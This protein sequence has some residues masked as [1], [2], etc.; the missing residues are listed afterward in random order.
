MKKSVSVKFPS[1][2]TRMTFISRPN[3][4]ILHCYSQTTHSVEVVHLADPGRLKELLIE[5]VGIYVLPSTNPN[6]KTKWTA[7]LVE[8]KEG[9]VSINTTF[10]NMLVDKMVK[11]SI[12]PELIDYK[13]IKSEYTYGHSRWDFLLEH[14]NGT[15]LLLEVK[16]VTL[17][18][19]GIGMF[20]DAITARGTKH[21]KEITKIAQEENIHTAILFI[22]QREDVERITSAPHIDK[23]FAEALIE[24]ENAG[25]MLIGYNCK[26]STQDIALNSAVPVISKNIYDN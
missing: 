10:P 24:A 3:R 21:V 1:P 4:F 22:A 23:K 13:W 19:N 7:V 9:L 20:P 16:S 25:V 15:S 12:I 11:Q 26:L 8:A 2:L 14:Y 18:E 5:G 6:R 17:A